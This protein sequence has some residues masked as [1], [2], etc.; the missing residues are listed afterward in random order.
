MKLDHSVEL[1]LFFGGSA[2]QA[3]NYLFFCQKN[4]VFG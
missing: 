2:F 3:Y 4:E 1:L